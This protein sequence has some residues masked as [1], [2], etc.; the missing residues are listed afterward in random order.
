MEKMDKELTAPKWVLIN[1]SKIIQRPQ[2]LSA[3]IVC[4]IPKVCYFN[5]KKRLHWVSVVRVLKVSYGFFSKYLGYITLSKALIDRRPEKKTWSVLCPGQ[6]V[7]LPLIFQ[8]FFQLMNLS[9]KT[10]L[11]ILLCYSTRT[12]QS[13][14]EPQ[15]GKTFY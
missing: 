10:H 2:N 1:W 11:T 13:C 9:S 15:C 8:H 3:Q 12:L 14:H 5:L 7:H 6:P 4:S